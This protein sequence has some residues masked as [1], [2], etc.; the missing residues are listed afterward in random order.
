VIPSIPHN[1]W[2][3]VLIRCKQT[4]IDVYI[5]GQIAKSVV[6]PSIPK[7]NY[8]NVFVAPNGGFD[9]YISN[10]W[11]YDYALNP[12]EIS[13]LVSQG[14]NT[15]M[16]GTN[17]AMNSRNTNYLSLRWFFAGEGAGYNP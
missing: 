10:L 7:Q 13:G 8:G 1:K 15:K 5:N 3:N 2:L 11:Y 4:L 9:G 12:I 17:D 16:I 6:L 14:P